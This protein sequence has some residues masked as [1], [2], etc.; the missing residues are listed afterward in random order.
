ME[1]DK[2]ST[3]A[4]SRRE[5]N[6]PTRTYQLLEK[7]LGLRKLAGSNI[8]DFSGF[9]NENKGTIRR[10]VSVEREIRFMKELWESLMMKQE[11]I[12][13]ENKEMKDMF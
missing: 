11:L 2:E 4:W 6:K 5:V 12:E 8:G 9:E 3:L 7:T 13:K 10:L 1:R